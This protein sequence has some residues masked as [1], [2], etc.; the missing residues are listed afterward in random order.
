[1]FEA[2][3]FWLIKI[4]TH[5]ETNKL[6]NLFS[7]SIYNKAFKRVK[8]ISVVYDVIQIQELES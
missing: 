7:L 5:P 1:M 3:K 6:S 8:L 2:V 4:V